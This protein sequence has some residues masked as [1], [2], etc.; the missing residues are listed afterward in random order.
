METIIPRGTDHIES[1]DIVFFT[2][3]REHVNEVQLQAGKT[4]FEVKKV[5]IMGGSRV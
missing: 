3:T 4:D 2:T 1:G 5:I